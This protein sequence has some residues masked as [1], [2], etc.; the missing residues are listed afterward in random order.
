MKKRPEHTSNNPQLPQWTFQPRWTL[1]LEGG[2]GEGGSER[3]RKGEA[4][5]ER[6]R[7]QESRLKE[8]GECYK[9][10]CV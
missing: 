1:T 10:K 8:S 4:E 2:G 5:G 3:T 6:E 7:E 9:K